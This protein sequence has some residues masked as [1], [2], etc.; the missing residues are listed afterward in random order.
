MKTTLELP[1]LLFRRAKAHAANQG[2]TLKQLFTE[3]LEDRLRQGNERNKVGEETVPWMSGFG[4]LSHLRDENR[5]L[6]ER[7]EEEFEKVDPDDFR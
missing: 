2:I 5:E 6:L 7:I 3:A 4:V 1:D